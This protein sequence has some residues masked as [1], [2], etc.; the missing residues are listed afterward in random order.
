MSPMVEPIVEHRL[1]KSRY[2][3]G[4]QC[5]KQLWWRVQ[6]P[7]APE[8]V[9]DLETRARFEEGHR[10]GERARRRF[11]GGVMITGPHDDLPARV[12]ATRRALAAGAPVIYEASFLA[13]SVY[14]AVDILERVEGGFV[15]V[16]VKSST[17][18]RSEH[19]DDVAVAAGDERR[20][21]SMPLARKTT[22]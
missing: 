18:P 20:P 5:H 9:P 2:L 8:L 15:L 14:V 7:R 11:P 19:L 13:D 12:E 17:E 3:H 16:E 22:S 21:T 1:S 10:V 4:L 6:E